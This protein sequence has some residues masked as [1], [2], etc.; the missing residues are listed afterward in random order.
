MNKHRATVLGLTAGLLGGGA[1]GLLLGVPALTNAAGDR[2]SVVEQD[3]GSTTTTEPG[4]TQPS[5]TEPGAPTDD[6]AVDDHATFDPTARI[7]AALQNLVD[8][9]TITSEQAD[10]VAADLAADRP[11]RGDHGGFGHHGRGGHPGFDG[12]V[13]ADLLGVTPEE[14]RDAL[15][16]GQSIADV[17]AANG[18]DVQTVID[19]LVAEAET[20]H[21]QAV[22]DGRLTQ[23]EADE[24]LAD[25]TERV[26]EM[27]NRSRP[28]DG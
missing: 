27:V 17:A 23:D 15:R 13:V 10:A 16:D 21:D 9:G 3:D 6:Q 18:V 24:R 2:I 7:R 25:I 14:L 20:H 19:A 8:D 5:T 11:A 4:T 26:T 12:E 22:T 1:A 28:V